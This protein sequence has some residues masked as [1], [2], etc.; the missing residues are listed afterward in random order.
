MISVIIPALNEERALPAT[1]ANLFGQP[2]NFEAILVDGGSHDAT[3]SVATD[4]PL[5]Q[6]VSSSPG[7]A[8]QMNAGAAAASGDTLLFL[9]A[10]T[11]LPEEALLRLN[12]LEADVAVWGGFHQ[13]FSSATRALQM[14]SS[15]HNW[16]CKQTGVFYGDQAMFVS[17]DLFDG[18][19]GFPA[20][21]ILEDIRLSEI[22]LQQAQPVF[23]PE[24]VITDARKFEQMG[25]LRSFLRCILILICF[26][27][28][29]PVLGQR[30]F[31]AIR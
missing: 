13:Q 10:D 25:P 28:R 3:L 4:W 27:L 23:L 6:V 24:H 2:G 12:A 22:L 7:R 16:R 31:S 21:P 30:F 11:L 26:E 15:L 14:V 8:V 19:G 17:R 9:H 29:L 18:A 1:L 20:E 5:L